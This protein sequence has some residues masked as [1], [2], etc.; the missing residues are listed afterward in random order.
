MP[1]KFTFQQD[2]NPK[3]TANL[4]GSRWKTP[5]WRFCGA[6]WKPRSRSN[7]KFVE[8][9][10]KRSLFPKTTWQGLSCFARQNEKKLQHPN[11]PAWLRQ[12][13]TDSAVSAAKGASSKYWP[14]GR[15]TSVNTYPTHFQL[16]GICLLKKKKTV[17]FTLTWKMLFCKLP[18]KQ[19]YIECEFIH[20]SRKRWKHWREWI[21]FIGTVLMQ[22]EMAQHENS[23]GPIK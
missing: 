10:E 23:I 15:S 8:G 17:F 16:I 6:E 21:V 20:L 14:E 1:L 5:K 7:R 3:D 2:Y 11:V 19:N 4:Q 13:Y 22:R 12:I 9:F 18:N